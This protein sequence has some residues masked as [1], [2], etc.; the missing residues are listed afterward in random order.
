MRHR[1]Y[2]E[3]YV[4]AGLLLAVKASGHLRIEILVGKPGARIQQKP[5]RAGSDSRLIW[6]ED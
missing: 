1:F 6:T 4:N 2:E 5:G 3:P